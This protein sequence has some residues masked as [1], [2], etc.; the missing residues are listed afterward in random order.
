MTKSNLFFVAILFVLLF[1][2]VL[3][4]TMKNIL[5]QQEDFQPCIRRVLIS[6]S[7]PSYKGLYAPAEKVLVPPSGPS[8]KGSYP[9]PARVFVP[10]SGPSHNVPYPPRSRVPVPPSGPSHKG[11]YP[12]VATKDFQ[13]RIRRVIVSP[14]GPSH[15]GPHPLVATKANINFWSPSQRLAF[16]MLPKYVPIP[17]SA[18]QNKETTLRPPRPMF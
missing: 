2:G 7:G 1:A 14:S 11:P 10:P 9:P 8:H 5:H 15:K 17:P 6:T 4:A 16:R 13:P 3:E 18:P 12:P